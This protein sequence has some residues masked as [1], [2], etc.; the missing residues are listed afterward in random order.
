DLRHA[1]EWNEP[2]GGEFELAAHLYGVDSRG[3]LRSRFSLGEG[4]SRVKQLSSGWAHGLLLGSMLGGFAILP[5]C[6]QTHAREGS[7]TND[8]GA[9]RVALL[10]GTLQEERYKKDQIYF[11]T[12]ARSLGLSP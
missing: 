3:R 6:E 10:L 12:K 8:S 11:E 9:V 1:F 5:A 2:L 4:R 7:P